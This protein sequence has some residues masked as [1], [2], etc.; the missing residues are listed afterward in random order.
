MDQ[1]G[2]GFFSFRRNK[3][4]PEVIQEDE[5]QGGQE[6]EEQVEQVG[7]EGQGGEEE[8]GQVGE[9]EAEGENDDGDF[10]PDLNPTQQEKIKLDPE[11]ERLR[12][13]SSL[14][15][16]YKSDDHLDDIYFLR[17][18]DKEK[19]R[20]FK[21][22]IDQA[23]KQLN[24]DYKIEEIVELCKSEFEQYENEAVA[25]TIETW[26][27]K[28]G[29]RAKEIYDQVSDEIIEK[30]EQRLAAKERLKILVEEYFDD[31]E[32][33]KIIPHPVR[34]LVIQK[35]DRVLHEKCWQSSALELMDIKIRQSHESTRMA[36]DLY[37]ENE[38]LREQFKQESESKNKVIDEYGE[39][40]DRLKG[41]KEELKEKKEKVDR[42]KKEISILNR[43]LVKAE[44]QCNKSLLHKRSKACKIIRNRPRTYNMIP[45]FGGGKPKTKHKSLKKSTRRKSTRKRLTKKKSTRR[46]SLEKK[47]SRKKLSRRR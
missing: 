9:T 46:K 2:A 25:V 40:I 45:K 17:K 24:L 39:E 10:I 28:M 6:G 8:V 34:L 14:I 35:I 13:I 31:D 15:G 32:N 11:N 22:Y 23:W 38:Q 19:E 1:N 29:E 41:E 20:E 27:G 37:I 44:K 21:F 47:S 16:D 30:R 4:S 33:I 36:D 12:R 26:D 3:V 42:L 7:E 18:R 5:G 43:T